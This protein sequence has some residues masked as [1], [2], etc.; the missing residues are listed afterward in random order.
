M[1]TATGAQTLATQAVSEADARGEEG[2]G[3][4][5]YDY[6]AAEYALL[7]GDLDAAAGRY[8]AA[9]E[10]LPGY[11]LALAG[12]GRVAYARGDTP[13]A[14][15][16]LE[17]A[18]AAVP[19]P[20]MRRVPGR[21]VRAV[22]RIGR[23]Q[24]SS[25]PRSTS[26]PSLVGQGSER[27]YDRDTACSW[28]IT[29]RRCAAVDACPD[30]ARRRARTSTATTRTPGRSMPHGRDAEALTQMSRRWRW[31]RPTPSC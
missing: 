12:E 21:P 20:D 14:I 26:S 2:A 17:R 6:A 22:R 19:R 8:A 3:L 28:P 4:A 10:E 29:V 31:A 25:T 23:R 1:A 24:T 27:V 13:G 15:A 18:V 30:R 5:F 16:Y 11:A 7:A 9:L